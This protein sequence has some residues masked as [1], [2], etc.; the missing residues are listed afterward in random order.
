MHSTI[1]IPLRQLARDTG[2]PV[3]WLKAEAEAGRIPSLRV[4]RR[5]LFDS[6]VVKR[7][8]RQR[9]KRQ[10]AR[11]KQPAEVH[12]SQAGCSHNVKDG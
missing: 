12:G 2:L 11:M 3:A 10:R 4:G 9:A 1:Y 8:L 7:T 5:L 6:K